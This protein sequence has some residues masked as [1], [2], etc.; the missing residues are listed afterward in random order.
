MFLYSEERQFITAGSRLQETKSSHNKRQDTT[1]LIREVIDKLKEAKF[2]NKLDLI[3]GYNNVW[4]KEEDKQKASFLMNKGLFKPQ[5]MY[6]GLCNLPETFQRMMNSIFQELLHEGVL[7]NHMDDFVIPAE[8][9]KQL[10]ER[11]I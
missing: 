2:F 1:F 10:E 3:W 8:M 7:A 4:I 11:T 9:K 6:F 5:V